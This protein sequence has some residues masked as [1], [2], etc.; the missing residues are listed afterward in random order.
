MTKIYRQS[1]KPSI[2]QKSRGHRPICKV[3]DAVRSLD[4]AL[5]IQDQLPKSQNPADQVTLAKKIADAEVALRSAQDLATKTQVEKQIAAKEL[6]DLKARL[7]TWI[8]IP[9]N[10]LMLATLS[11]GTGVISSLISAVNEESKTAVVNS[12]TLLQDNSGRDTS[13]HSLSGVR[14]C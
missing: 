2:K 9:T 8:I 4:E 13:Y 6:V 7:N 10:L 12:V 3:K 14:T 11:I 1:D 5:A